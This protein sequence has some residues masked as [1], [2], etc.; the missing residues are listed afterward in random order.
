ME[1]QPRHGVL[2]VVSLTLVEKGSLK[3]N[4]ILVKH[5]VN[6]PEDWKLKLARFYIEAPCDQGRALLYIL[7]SC[8]WRL[9]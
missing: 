3:R 6:F 5:V 7:M 1:V 8:S 2:L 9:A 4:F